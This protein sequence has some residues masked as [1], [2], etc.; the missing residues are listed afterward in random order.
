MWTRTTSLRPVIT[1][2]CWWLTGTCPQVET[3]TP[4]MLWVINTRLVIKWRK[5]SQEIH[6]INSRRRTETSCASV[7]CGQLSSHS[8]A[9]S[10]PNMMPQWE[11]VNHHQTLS[12]LHLLSVCP[13]PTMC[14]SSCLSVRPPPPSD[15]QTHLNCVVFYKCQSLHEL[16]VSWQNILTCQRR[17]VWP[18][19]MIYYTSEWWS[20]INI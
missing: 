18:V 12:V 13:P 6:F 14:L 4:A 20:V 8:S 16:P 9:S 15:W 7:S 2:S 5:S 17:R 3:W 1:S 11:V 10:K 19:L